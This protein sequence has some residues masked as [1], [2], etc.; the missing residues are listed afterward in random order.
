MKGILGE[1]KTFIARGNVVDLAVGL[2]IG[3]SF[4]KIVSSLVN[5]IIMPPIGMIIGR[6]NFSELKYVIVEKTE[7]A[8][9]VAIYYGA[10]LQTIFDFLLIGFSVFVIVKIINKLSFKKEKEVEMEEEVIPPTKQ[11]LLLEEI[12]D[13]LR[14]KR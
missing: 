13:L 1:F 9:E 4:G 7:T 3:T 5:D 11:E 6:V 10:F 14:A 2:L 12:R 8:N